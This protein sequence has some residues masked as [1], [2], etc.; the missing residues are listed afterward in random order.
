PTVRPVRLIIGLYVHSILTYDQMH[1]KTDQ[2][3]MVYKERITPNGTQPTYDTWI[4]L[5][6]Q[7]EMDYPQVS[8]ATRLAPLDGTVTIGDQS[9]EEEFQF[10]DETFFDV[11]DFDLA[12]GNADAPF[13]DLNSVIINQ[14]VALRLFGDKD[15]VGQRISVRESFLEFEKDYTVSGVL[16]EFPPNNSITPTLL[17]PIESIPEFEQYADY[18][19]GSFL[20]TYV[21]INDVAQRQAMEATF[22]DLVEK[23]WDERTRNN[24]NLKL[25]PLPEVYDTMIGDA[26]NAY[27][28]LYVAIA[29]LLIAVFNF[30]NLSTAHALDRAKEVGVRKVLGALAGSIRWQ[31]ALETI[32]IT[33]MATAISVFLA[34][35]LLPTVNE[36]LEMEL[37]L[38]PFLSVEIGAGQLV[39]AILL[40]GL[41]A[42]YPSIHLSRLGLAQLM[43]GSASGRGAGGIRNVMMTIQ[44]A[45]GTLM[46]ISTLGINGQINHM[47]ETDMG[48]NKER[49]ILRT[50]V[51]DFENPE[52]GEVR[53]KTF[54]DYLQNT[55][56]IENITVSRHVPAEWSRSF[57]FAR[58]KGWEGDPLRMRYTYLDASFFDAYDIPMIDGDGFLPDRNGHQRADVVLN[59]A[60]LDAFGWSDIEDKVIMVGNNQLRVVGL[61]KD[62]NF[63]S[64]REEVAPTLM[65]HRTADHAVHRYI[66]FDL[67]LASANEVIPALEEQWIAL[68]ALTTLDYNFLDEQVA[69]MYQDEARLLNLTQW[70]TVLAIFIAA[71]GLYGLSTFVVERKRREI[72]IRKVLG[73]SISQLWL[74]ITEK[75]VTLYLVAFAIGGVGA[76]FFLSQWLVDFAFRADISVFTFAMALGSMLL[77]IMATV[78]YKTITAGKAN[79]VVYLRDE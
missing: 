70:F 4:P 79:P 14:E 68:G 30:M 45:L 41:S 20:F 25:L 5:K 60:A 33:V 3:Y 9:F 42:S 67:P 1:S 11:F 8:S 15:P 57:L 24:T 58:P 22:P 32:L 59:Q 64:L 56:G 51:D 62:F 47:I 37:S 29:I 46:I 77:M 27:L 65:M 36:L 39:F 16:A 35:L 78:S 31:F 76:Y 49:I 21:V 18:W 63:E 50:S 13:D 19:D 34:F 10:V 74:L 73:A 52:I 61:V 2:I 53:M 71:L 43:V 23:I 44:F 6:G 55:A 72:S 40:G 69:S 17:F 26:S 7:L 38:E 54:K 12:N 28:M 48:F 75:F 66:S